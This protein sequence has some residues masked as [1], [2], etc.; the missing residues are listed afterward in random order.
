MATEQTTEP[1][2]YRTEEGRVCALIVSRGRKWLGVIMAT[3]PIRIAKVPLTEERYMRPLDAR[4][5]HLAKSLR[6]IGRR[7][8]ITDTAKAALRGK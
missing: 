3:P 4:V 8:S 6:R 7:T 5:S 2:S 1:V